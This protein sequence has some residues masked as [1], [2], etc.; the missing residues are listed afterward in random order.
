MRNKHVKSTTVHTAVL[1]QEIHE[2]IHKA[3]SRINFISVKQNC[4]SI[5]PSLRCMFHGIGLVLFFMFV[6]FIYYF[7][8]IS[9]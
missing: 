3:A 8:F 1:K 2:F 6:F 4:M 5:L 7:F 9:F